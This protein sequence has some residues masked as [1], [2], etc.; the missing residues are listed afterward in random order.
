MSEGDLVVWLIESG[1]INSVGEVDVAR[2]TE[3]IEVLFDE[4][5]AIRNEFI[6]SRTRNGKP[7]DVKFL[8][9][10]LKVLEA[11]TNGVSAKSELLTILR[12]MSRMT[13]LRKVEPGFINA[14]GDLDSLTSGLAS[15]SSEDRT[16]YLIEFFGRDPATLNTW[17]KSRHL[18]FKRE[19]CLFL[20]KPFEE[21]INRILKREEVRRL[22]WYPQHFMTLPLEMTPEQ[23]RAEVMVAT[24]WKKM[25]EER[26]NEERRREEQ[27]DEEEYLAR[28]EHQRLT[29]E[30]AAAAAAEEAQ[31]QEANDTP[32]GRLALAAQ[33]AREDSV[34]V[35]HYF[36]DAK[37]FS[38]DVRIALLQD[39]ET[40]QT[41]TALGVRVPNVPGHRMEELAQIEDLHF[42]SPRLFEFTYPMIADA[43][44]SLPYGENL[45]FIF[46]GE[47]FLPDS[48]AEQ[49]PVLYSFVLNGKIADVTLHNNWFST[50]YDVTGCHSDWQYSFIQFIENLDLHRDQI[51]FK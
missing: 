22:I 25:E 5:G 39:E 37:W 3:R 23:N 4:Q 12:A 42:W 24:A 1:A 13:A 27:R 40:R 46:D 2:A 28:A 7:E 32:H 41:L 10:S 26:N 38:V 34:H 19:I 20:S 18:E 35:I 15:F 21:F 9:H 16:K 29:D 49:D 43:V 8:K 11:S 36:L 30:R 33:A 50:T 45:Q 6:K 17:L 51:I 31:A 44:N 47:W 48:I 14:T